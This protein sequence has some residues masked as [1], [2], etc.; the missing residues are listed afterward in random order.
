MARIEPQNPMNIYI[1]AM[2]IAVHPVY[3]LD[4][5]PIYNIVS[6]VMPVNEREHDATHNTFPSP[7]RARRLSTSGWYL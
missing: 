6:P 7:D 4:F 2:K 5:I 3:L 1:A